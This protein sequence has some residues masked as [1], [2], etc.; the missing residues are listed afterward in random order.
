MKLAGLS[1][2][3]RLGEASIFF[4]LHLLGERSVDKGVALPLGVLLFLFF[5]QLIFAAIGRH[6]FISSEYEFS[7]YFTRRLA[8]WIDLTTQ[9]WSAGRM[10]RYDG[11]SRSVMNARGHDKRSVL[12]AKKKRGRVHP[13]WK[14]ASVIF[15]SRT[16]FDKFQ[17]LVRKFRCGRRDQIL[18]SNSVCCIMR[19]LRNELWWGGEDGRADRGML[20]RSI[21]KCK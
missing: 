3:Q 17:R 8:R 6:R 14:V 13:F 2:L 10:R 5:F 20:N 15:D 16:P 7:W 9:N 11:T 1:K 18:Y 12:F 19:A 21:W 4:F